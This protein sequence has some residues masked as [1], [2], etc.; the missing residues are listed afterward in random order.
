MM[1]SFSNGRLPALIG[2]RLSCDKTGWHRGRATHVRIVRV[3]LFDLFKH[4]HILYPRLI[5]NS[6]SF[7]CLRLPS[8]GVTGWSIIPLYLSTY[9]LVSSWDQAAY[10]NPLK[11]PEGPG[12]Y[13]NVAASSLYEVKSMSP[14]D[15]A[16]LHTCLGTTLGRWQSSSSGQINATRIKR[17]LGN[18]L[19][20]AISVPRAHV[21]QHPAPRQKP[22]GGGHT[23][24][25]PEPT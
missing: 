17:L 11:C 2:Q 18:S 16:F 8:I 21:R 9:I 14:V 13:T 24:A 23:H 10:L 20:K 1:I 25:V 4:S 5:A 6:G 15:Q 19:L 7:S 3:G 22:L 12:L